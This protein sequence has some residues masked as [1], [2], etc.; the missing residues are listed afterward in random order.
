MESDWRDCEHCN[1]MGVVEYVIGNR[2]YGDPEADYEE[3]DCEYCD[4]LGQVPTDGE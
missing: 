4:G 3:R 1:G 2:L